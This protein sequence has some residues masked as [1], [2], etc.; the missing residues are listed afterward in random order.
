MI[1]RGSSFLARDPDQ[2]VVRWGWVFWFAW[3]AVGGA[4]LLGDY[5]GSVLGIGLVLSAPFWALWLMWP[6]YRGARAVMRAVWHA[7]LEPWDGRYY[8]FDGRQVRIFFEDDDVWFAAA[9][10]F[11]ALGTATTARDAERVRQI[12]GRD[13]LRHAPVSGLL[14]FSEKGLAA[15]LDRRTERTA[16]QFRRWV[17][18]QV[19]APYRRRY[20][21]E[22]RGDAADR[23]EPS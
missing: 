10:V 13:G 16:T 12:V 19:V 6:L 2:R 4:L 22:G 20:E 23:S 11:D 17:E 21:L 15:W 18:T 5:R 8:E 14:C 7:G 1:Q 9:D 3:I